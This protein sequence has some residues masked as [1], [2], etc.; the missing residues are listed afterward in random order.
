M[1]RC[2][3]RQ[4]GASIL[5]RRQRWPPACFRSIDLK[6]W[7]RGE[8]P[9]ASVDRLKYFTAK[10]LRHRHRP[11]VAGRDR[12]PQAIKAEEAGMGVWDNLVILVSLLQAIAA[13]MVPSVAAA[14]QAVTSCFVKALRSQASDPGGAPIIAQEQ[15]L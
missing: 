5:A 2:A 4:A 14:R 6:P 11:P 12:L 1:T 13:T 7:R 8:G 3:A 10:A 15:P 9:A